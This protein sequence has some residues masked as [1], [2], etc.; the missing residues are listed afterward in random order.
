MARYIIDT[1]KI[2]IPAGFF[3]DL[4]VPKL[5]KWLKSQASVEV[6]RPVSHGYV[7]EHEGHEDEYYCECSICGSH[8]V[9]LRDRYCSEC[10][11]RLDLFPPNVVIKCDK[12]I[13]NCPIKRPNCPHYKKD[14]PD[15]GYYG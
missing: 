8:E 10:G 5:F 4:N 14:A 13:H 7:I 12:C 9:C 2:T 3:N 11:S 15:G 1:E 6:V